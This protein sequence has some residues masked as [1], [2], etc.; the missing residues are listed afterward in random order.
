VP[1]NTNRLLPFNDDNTPLDV[2]PYNSRTVEHETNPQTEAGTPQNGMPSNYV[3]HGFRP[4]FPLQAAELNEIQEQFIM[5]QSLTISMMHNW[6]TSS[7]SSMWDEALSNLLSA[8]NNLPEG[9]GDGGNAELAISAPGWRGTT[10]LYPF[11][12]SDPE[13]DGPSN[14]STRLVEI[15]RSVNTIQ[16]VFRRGWYLTEL[17]NLNNQPNRADG[18]KY[19]TLL[20]YSDEDD[21]TINVNAASGQPEKFVG[22]L[23]NKELV[24]ACS[25][26]PCAGWETAL[27]TDIS[28]NDNAAGNY[29]VNTG[30]SDRYRISFTGAISTVSDA[31]DE[32]YVSKVLKVLPDR[33]EVRYMNNLLLL[34]WE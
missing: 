8:T 6:I 23:V 26:E 32:N 2:A 27:P 16:V 14:W 29:N 30:G 19:W 5:Q 17:H 34:K 12:V 3:L 22:L 33:K 10:P 15:S 9:L 7:Y 25:V 21:F 18:F 4:G 13:S 31:T 20:D 1:I 28:L 24:S 11:A